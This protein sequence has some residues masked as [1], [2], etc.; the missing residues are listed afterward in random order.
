MVYSVCSA[1]LTAPRIAY[2]NCRS[3][4]HSVGR[5]LMF[6]RRAAVR[7][8]VQS[9]GLL[10]LKPGEQGKARSLFLRNLFPCAWFLSVKLSTLIL[11]LN[12]Q[13]TNPTR[14][15]IPF[16]SHS[17]HPPPFPSVNFICKPIIIQPHWTGT[18]ESPSPEH[19]SASREEAQSLNSAVALGHHDLLLCILC[20]PYKKYLQCLKM[21]YRKQGCIGQH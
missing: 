10:M 5:M 21:C 9:H 3:F 14:L 4:Q 18:N 2:R 6:I 17:V 20:N 19:G 13:K 12:H 15:P 1:L 11:I 7:E 8:P 16:I